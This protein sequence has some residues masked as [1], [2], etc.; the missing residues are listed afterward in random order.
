MKVINFYGGAGAGKSTLASALF[1]RLRLD[2]QYNCELVPEFAKDVVYEGARRNLSDQLY[3]L[4]NQHH[5]LWR[6]KQENVEIAICDSPI[7]MS[8]AY[9]MRLELPWINDLQRLVNS[10]KLQYTEYNI[11]VH[12]EVDGKFRKNKPWS[13]NIDEELLTNIIFNTEVTYNLYG[14]ILVYNRVKNWLSSFQ[15]DG[16]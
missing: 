14:E 13:L 4:G 3:L 5:R 9:A 7:D 15:K 10:L 2:N 16:R 1:Y 6:L 11:F 12:R 8:I